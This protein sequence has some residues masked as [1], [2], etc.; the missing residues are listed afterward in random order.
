MVEEDGGDSQDVGTQRDTQAV[1][2]AFDSQ[3]SDPN[4]VAPSSSSESESSS[5]DEEQFD[6]EDEDGINVP[7][8]KEAPS[9]GEEES[10]YEEEGGSGV[11]ESEDRDENQCHFDKSLTPPT[12]HRPVPR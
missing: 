9:S 7:T 8:I 4:N 1:Y 5:E 12:N 2:S 10:A 11:S 3:I 6:S